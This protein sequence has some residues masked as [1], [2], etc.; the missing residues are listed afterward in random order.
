MSSSIKL[1]TFDLDDT[2]WHTKPVLIKAEQALYQWL[3]EHC[4][5]LT[6][7]YS[8]K[9]LFEYRLNIAASFPQWAHDPTKLRIET[10]RRALLQTGIG[11]EKANQLAL[12]A[13]DIF[14][15]HRNR[16]ELFDDVEEVM[17]KLKQQYTI[18]AVSNGNSD[19]KR[20]GIEHLFDEHFSAE[21]VGKAKPDPEMFL[22]AFESSGYDAQQAIHIGDHP[23]EDILTA[24]NLGMKTIW[25][26]APCRSKE[27]KEN[28]QPQKTATNFLELENHIAALS[29]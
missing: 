20:I 18:I 17:N 13:F 8:L 11:R 4:P 1:L 3:S 19:L 21:K 2:L 15:D 26:N 12:D 29:I 24:Q 28:F 22:K 27:W 23:T 16:I 7:L 10:L 5:A 14:I 9:A 25:Y 6:D